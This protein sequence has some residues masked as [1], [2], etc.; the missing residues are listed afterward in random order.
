MY[1]LNIRSRFISVPYC[2]HAGIS[3]LR[4]IGNLHFGMFAIHE[5]KFHLKA[6]RSGCIQ[7]YF[8]DMAIRHLHLKTGK[9]FMAQP[10][11]FNTELKKSC[12]LRQGKYYSTCIIFLFITQYMHILLVPI[13]K[14]GLSPLLPYSK[15][16]Q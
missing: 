12:T 14:T 8:K 9:N 10:V 15:K 7:R 13:F 3:V 6:I 5:L 16:T 2:A 4:N 11:L 1:T